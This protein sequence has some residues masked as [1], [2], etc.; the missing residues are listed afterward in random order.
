VLPL[1]TVLT[2]EPDDDFGAELEHAVT[3]SSDTMP[4]TARETAFMV[5]NLS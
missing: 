5:S 1:S 4:I 3:P 2:S